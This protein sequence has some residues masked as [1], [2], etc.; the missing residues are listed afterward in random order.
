[1]WNEL[2]KTNEQRN[3]EQKI[4]TRGALGNTYAYIFGEQAYKETFEDK[5][6]PAKIQLGEKKEPQQT[7]KTTAR[8]RL[9]G[10][11]SRFGNKM[12]G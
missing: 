10:K 9:G 3:H 2:K 12:S 4:K 8:R 5:A 6:K 7:T 11:G 1:M